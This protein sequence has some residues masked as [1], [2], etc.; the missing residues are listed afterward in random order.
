MSGSDN[1]DVDSLDGSDETAL[2]SLIEGSKKF[3]PTL[4]ARRAS[5]KAMSGLF[6]TAKTISRKASNATKEIKRRVST[7]KSGDSIVSAI[8]ARL[9]GSDSQSME[10]RMLELRLEIIDQV[11]DAAARQEKTQWLSTEIY[12]D[13]N[14]EKLSYK[15]QAEFLLEALK[16]LG[17][18]KDVLEPELAEKVEDLDR[19]AVIKCAEDFIQAY[20]DNVKTALKDGDLVGRYADK[21]A[22]ISTTIFC[23][24][25]MLVYNMLLITKRSTAHNFATA[26]VSLAD[27]A[28]PTRTIAKQL[29]SIEEASKNKGT[30]AAVALAM[31]GGALVLNG[32]ATP[33]ALLIAIALATPAPG[34]IDKDRV[35]DFIHENLKLE[36]STARM[37]ALKALNLAAAIQTRT[38]GIS[39]SSKP[40]N[41]KG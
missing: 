18:P 35:R 19:K 29:A 4:T 23:S 38:R 25:I 10:D 30:P 39:T 1:D 8:A 40:R 31:A 37:G 34:R 32:S 3:D 26:M 11:L 12:D 27:G 20:K 21:Y 6:G 41:K 15:Q 28:A 16:L 7:T 9:H 2:S 24:L 33:A 22:D 5:S 14:E 13:N 36:V 17:L